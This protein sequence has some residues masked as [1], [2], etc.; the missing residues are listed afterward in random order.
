MYRK[1]GDFYYF[2]TPDQPV[3]CA[4][5]QHKIKKKPFRYITPEGLTFYK[6]KELA[7]H[8]K[9]LQLIYGPYLRFFDGNTCH[10]QMNF[11]RSE[12]SG[13][14]RAYYLAVERFS[15]FA[16]TSFKILLRLVFVNRQTRYNLIV[17]TYHLVGR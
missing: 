16:G 5:L 9:L 3:R 1:A 10:A 12:V 7:G 11:Y 17:C 13:K 15:L 6:R 8:F 4:F 14:L 2:T